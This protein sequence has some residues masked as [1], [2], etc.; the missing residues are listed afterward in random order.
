ME[1][2]PK[3]SPQN[4]KRLQ[5]MLRKHRDKELRDLERKGVSEEELKQESGGESSDHDVLP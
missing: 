2:Q 3:Q 5:S 4:A 1:Q